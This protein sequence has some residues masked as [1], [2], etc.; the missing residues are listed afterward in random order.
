[1]EKGNIL[2]IGAS[3]IDITGVPKEK[4]VKKDSNPGHVHISHGGV[5]R[6]IAENLARLSMKVGFITVLGE[7]SFGEAIAARL[8]NIGV[9]LHAKK[10]SR[11]PVYLA[12]HDSSKDMR[13]AV[14][15]MEGW[16]AFS[17]RDLHRHEKSIREAEAV[18]IDANLEKGVIDYVMKRSSQVFADAV[19]S[20]KAKRLTPYLGKVHTLKCNREELSTLAGESIDDEISLRE[21]LRRLHAQG[22]YRIAVT[23][24]AEGATLSDNQGMRHLPALPVSTVSTTGAGDAFTAGL[25]YAEMTEK[26]PLAVGIALSSFSLETANN[27]HPR[28]SAKRLAR[29]LPS[30]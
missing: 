20:A 29:R 22:V 26:P 30:G 27:V 25:A 21:A 12:I 1:M 14:N 4:L 24:G 17:A 6:N 2:V 16:A 5:G 10:V 23:M 19:S 18:I 9:V 3:N 13:L 11:T 28:L 8:E 15:D 7:D